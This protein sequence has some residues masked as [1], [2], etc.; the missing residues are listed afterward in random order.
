M[1]VIPHRSPGE[2]VTLHAG[3]VRPEERLLTLDVLMRF[4]E[5]GEEDE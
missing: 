1:D 3:P 2:S 4:P 5:S